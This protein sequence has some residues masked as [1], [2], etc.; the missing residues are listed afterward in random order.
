MLDAVHHVVGSASAL[1]GNCGIGFALVYHALVPHRA[2]GLTVRLPIRIKRANRNAVIP[3]PFSAKPVGPIS[4]ALND[5]CNAMLVLD[6]AE[7]GSDFSS[8]R[9]VPATSDD[10]ALC[11]AEKLA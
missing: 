5:D 6:C 8:V 1:E 2:C 9:I 11:H 7:N 4:A 3:S 10:D